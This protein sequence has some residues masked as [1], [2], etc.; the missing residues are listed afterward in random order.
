MQQIFSTQLAFAALKDGGS[1]ITW[2]DESSGGN[3]NDGSSTSNEGS[4]RGILVADG[5]CSNV[6]ASAAML[7]A[8]VESHL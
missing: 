1:V 3:S 4:S 5:S 6:A 8:L 7:L 2:G